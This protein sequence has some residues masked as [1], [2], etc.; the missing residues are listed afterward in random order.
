MLGAVATTR[1]TVYRSRWRGRVLPIWANLGDNLSSH[2]EVRISF[3]S[4]PLQNPTPLA[5]TRP[6]SL[7]PQSFALHTPTNFLPN[8]RVLLRPTAAGER[9]N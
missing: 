9:G 5:Q 6:S 8:T 3:D 2:R 7:L 4:E 1:E